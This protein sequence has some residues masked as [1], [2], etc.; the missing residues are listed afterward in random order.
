M[1]TA[2]LSMV[3]IIVLLLGVLAGS[4]G[5]T[6]TAAIAEIKMFAQP[7]NKLAVNTLH[8]W[9]DQYGKWSALGI[10]LGGNRDRLCSGILGWGFRLVD[11]HLRR[12]I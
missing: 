7:R 10:Y 11:K 2:R 6:A 3:G 8:Q 4:S 9:A 5:S 1:K 12:G